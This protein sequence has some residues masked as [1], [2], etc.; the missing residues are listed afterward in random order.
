MGIA[1]PILFEMAELSAVSM[2]Y[3]MKTGNQPEN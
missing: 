2:T 1:G 3:E